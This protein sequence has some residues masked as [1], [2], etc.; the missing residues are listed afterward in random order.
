MFATAATAA[1]TDGSSGQ[2]LKTDGSGAL[3]FATVSTDKLNESTLTIAPGSTGDYDLAEDSNQ[4]GSDES[5][6]EASADDQDAFGI[7]ITGNTYSFMDPA[8][9]VNSTDLGALS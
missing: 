8:N 3:S 7:T 6:F 4:N 9:Q 5:P 2:F 1:I